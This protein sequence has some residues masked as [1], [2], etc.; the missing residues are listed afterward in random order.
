MHVPAKC[1]QLAC[2][3]RLA[4]GTSAGPARQLTRSAAATA[5]PKPDPKEELKWQQHTIEMDIQ[6]IHDEM[7]ILKGCA[8]QC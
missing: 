4:R 7:N 2:G 3:P 6:E 5:P 8:L 1:K